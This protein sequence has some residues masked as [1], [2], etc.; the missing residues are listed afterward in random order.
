VSTDSQN[1]QVESAPHRSGAAWSPQ[2]IYGDN[3]WDY[4]VTSVGEGFM[5]DYYVNTGYAGW[6]PGIDLC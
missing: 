3:L 1:S 2:D 4:V 6:I 5:S